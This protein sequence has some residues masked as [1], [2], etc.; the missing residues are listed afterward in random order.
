MNDGALPWIILLGAAFLAGILLWARDRYR[1]ARHVPESWIRVDAL[2]NAE[3]GRSF[4][5]FI[6]ALLCV[7]R[8][9][10]AGTF[11]PGI[12]YITAALLFLWFCF[13]SYQNYKKIAQRSREQ[14]L[15]SHSAHPRG[16][17]E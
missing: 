4:V 5:C 2:K 13:R 3:G 8:A 9:I 6:F 7:A 1:K 16:G 10:Q 14:N 15:D 17:S 12:Y 11:V